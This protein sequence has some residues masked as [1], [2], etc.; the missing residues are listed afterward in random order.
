MI[1]LKLCITLVFVTHL[2]V[3]ASPNSSDGGW[4]RNPDQAEEGKRDFISWEDYC[5]ATDPIF[6][7]EECHVRFLFHFD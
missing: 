4:W 1:A 7:Q 3:F 5:A 6:N 2:G